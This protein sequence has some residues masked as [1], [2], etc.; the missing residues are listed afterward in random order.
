MG[1][2]VTA[3]MVPMVIPIIYMNTRA[4]AIIIKDNKILLIHRFMKDW[5]EYWVF[6]GGGV[7]DGETTEQAMVREV[8]EELSLTVTESKL[9]FDV[10]NPFTMGGHFPPRQEYYYLVTG[11]VGDVK[12]GGSEAKE[13]SENNE[14][15]PTWVELD[16]LREMENLKPEVVK[17]KLL[18]ILSL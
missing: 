5:G 16:K 15:Y 8:M 10:F 12:L 4:G 1:T 3:T 2:I 9:L 14:Y 18:E 17:E 6:P 7:D 11:F 13:M